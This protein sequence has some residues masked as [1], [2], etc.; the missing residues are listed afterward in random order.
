MGSVP[1][2]F[3]NKLLTLSTGSPGV[4]TPS[5]QRAKKRDSQCKT[6]GA[7]DDSNGAKRLLGSDLPA[8][9]LTAVGKVLLADLPA[10]EQNSRPPAERSSCSS[11]ARF[12]SPAAAARGLPAAATRSVLHQFYAIRWPISHQNLARGVRGEKESRGRVREE[13][14]RPRESRLRAI[15]NSVNSER[16]VCD[17]VEITLV[18]AAHA[19]WAVYFFCAEVSRLRV[20]ELGPTSLRLRTPQ[21]VRNGRTSERVVQLHQVY[22]SRNSTRERTPRGV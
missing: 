6:P 20:E 18:D 16:L 14:D 10:G 8:T 13:S 7:R 3:F 22:Q 5:C 9:L 1:V 19:D 2:P 17:A 11:P 4:N 21:Q 15:A 12:A